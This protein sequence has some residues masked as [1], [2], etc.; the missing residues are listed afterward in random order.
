MTCGAQRS[1]AGN[2][3]R[4]EGET[5]YKVPIIYYAFTHVLSISGW[6]KMSKFIITI[7][8]PSFRNL[9]QGGQKLKVGD[10]GGRDL[11]PLYIK[12]I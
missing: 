7:L 6:Q 2:I 11:Y 4:K 12:Y 8:W 9:A 10:L 1:F 3:A 5:G